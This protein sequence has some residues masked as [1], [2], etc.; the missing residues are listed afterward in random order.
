MQVKASSVS[1]DVTGLNASLRCIVFSEPAIPVL[2]YKMLVLYVCD[3]HWNVT[4]ILQINM[5]K[6]DKE[7][8]EVAARW[9]E[10]KKGTSQVQR[11]S[12]MHLQHLCF[13]FGLVDRYCMG[14]GCTLVG[15]CDFPQPHLLY[16]LMPSSYRFETVM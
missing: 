14:C 6:A 10:I 13:S 1:M 2:C 9:E 15:M 4:V 7:L 12:I 11:E 5:H 16:L 8:S 3:K